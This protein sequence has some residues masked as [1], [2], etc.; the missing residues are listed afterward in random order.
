[1]PAQT[2]APAK[3][4]T[5]PG[6]WLD[7]RDKRFVAWGLGGTLLFAFAL[8]AL[9][10]ALKHTDTSITDPD[11]ATAVIAP[12][13]ARHLVDFSLTDQ[14]G[15]AVTRANLQG[16]YVVVD[17]VFTGCSVTCPYVN[18]Q[19]EKVEQATQGQPVKLLSITLDPADDTVPVL[20]KYAPGFSAD[21]AR[22]SFLTGD[23]DAIHHL[24]GASFL[25]PDSSGEFSYMPGSFAHVQ[26]IVLVDPTGNVLSYFDGLNPKAADY[27]LAAIASQ[28]K[29]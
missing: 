20:A 22:W 3:T 8:G 6:S 4:Q 19:M 16:N 9:M 14:Q 2:N 29:S 27:V 11:A 1:M 24:V 26:R 13:Y 18:A 10:L 15:R 7:E 5:F 17:F 25:P 12:D 28:K 23:Q 21:P